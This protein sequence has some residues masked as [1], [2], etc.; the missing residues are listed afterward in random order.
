MCACA[1]AFPL[2]LRRALSSS[3]HF[4]KHVIYY[5]LDLIQKQPPIMR[6]MYA[7]IA[8]ENLVLLRTFINPERQR[9]CVRLISF[10][11]FVL[12]HLLSPIR[13]RHSRA[14]RPSFDSLCLHQKLLHSRSHAYEG[15]EEPADG[16]SQI[17]RCACITWPQKTHRST[18]KC[19]RC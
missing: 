11:V 8:T 5:I 15:A 12:F 14:R 6:C 4:A 9:N 19:V 1:N 18:A 7:N 16:E 17:D 2:A 3:H 10:F 13:N